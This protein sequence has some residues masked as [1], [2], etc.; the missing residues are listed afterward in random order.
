MDT[1][2]TMRQPM[3]QRAVP[4]VRRRLARHLRAIRGAQGLTQAAL[5]RKCGLTDKFIGE[6]ERGTKSLTV[7]SLARVAKALGVAPGALLA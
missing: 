4:V 1:P 6:V 2:R 7:D 3:S 5:S